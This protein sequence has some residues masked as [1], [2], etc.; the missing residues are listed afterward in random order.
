M[1]SS[2]LPWKRGNVLRSPHLDSISGLRL[3]KGA[4]SFCQADEEG[5]ISQALLDSA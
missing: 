5:N 4:F 3:R 2:K 1:T